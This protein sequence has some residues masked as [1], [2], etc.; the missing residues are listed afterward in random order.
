M[1]KFYIIQ[2]LKPEDPDLGEQVYKNIKDVSKAEYFKVTNRQELLDTLEYIKIDLSVD[3]TI[4]GIIHIHCHGNDKGIAMRDDENTREFV[5]WNELREKLREL[6]VATSN[7]PILSMCACKGFNASRLV[8][9]FQPCPYE[10]LTGSMIGIPFKDSVDGYSHFYKCLIDG[11]TMDESIKETRDNFPKMD[12]VCL[13][14]KQLFSIAVN[15][16]IKLEMTPEKLNERKE[17]TEKIMLASFTTLNEN[18]KQF[19]EYAYSEAG[20]KEYLEKYSSIFF[21]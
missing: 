16:Y 13:N 1:N 20:T 3:K 7:K 18:Q 9:H 19:L 15:G 5:L 8:A 12:F 11:K 6:Y 17:A 21:S 4:K 14:S 2:S 10:Y